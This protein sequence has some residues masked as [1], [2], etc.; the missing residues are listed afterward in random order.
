MSKKLLV[1]FGATGNQ[2]GSTAH[3]VLDDPSLSKTY[4]VRAITRS[5]SNPKAEALKAKGAEIV[6][7]DMDDAGSISRAVEGAH[8]IFA[9]T[10]TLYTGD[11]R[12]VETRQ[13]KTVCEAAL[14]HGAQYIIWSSMSHPFK[15]SNGKLTKVVHFDDKAEIEEYIRGLPIKSAFFAPGS[16]MQNLYNPQMAPRP[17]P[18]NDG[19]YVISNICKPD[20]L[21][22]WIDITETGK[23]IGAILAE[24]DKYEGKFFAA[25][26]ELA[27]Y[28]D[29]ADILTKVS[30]KTV[31]FHQMPDEQFQQ[32]MQGRE[33]LFEMFVLFREYGYYGPTMKEDVE[34]AAKQ[35]RGNLTGIEEF[36][37]RENFKL[38]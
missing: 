36:F 18:A 4:T 38:E 5:A 28:Q 35:A 33:F 12:A 19:T 1:V 26:T 34:W 10:T 23:W 7:A 6:E 17:S 9:V 16:F 15:I 3:F 8:T 2:G 25:A 32:I 21:L 29:I 30:G 13:A 14:K 20:T 37:R 27:S 11:T 24:P 31:K 22:P